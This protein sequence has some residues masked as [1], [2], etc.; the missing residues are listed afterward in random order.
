MSDDNGDRVVFTVNSPGG[1]AT[2]PDAVDTVPDEVF[3]VPVN[4][5]PSSI[6]LG[7]VVIDEPHDALLGKASVPCSVPV[8][9]MVPV[10]WRL[11]VDAFVPVSDPAIVP[12]ATVDQPPTL[13]RPVP[14]DATRLPV[15]A[16]F[17]Q[18]LDPEVVCR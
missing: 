4:S 12:V 16:T 13:T 10:V 2:S 14:V 3:S 8:P 9:W 15:V 7:C 6:L 1:T 18:L 5:V 17:D 11:P